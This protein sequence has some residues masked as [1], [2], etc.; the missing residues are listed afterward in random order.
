M[1]TLKGVSPAYNSLHMRTIR[2]APR[3]AAAVR[4]PLAAVRSGMA[5]EAALA[6]A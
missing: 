1:S 2:V 6:R 3:A 4:G 5:K